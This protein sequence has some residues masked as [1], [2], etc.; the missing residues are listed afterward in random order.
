MIIGTA[1]FV[2]PQLMESVRLFANSF[3]GYYENFMRHMEKLETRDTLMKYIGAAV[4]ELIRSAENSIPVI[5]EKAYSITSSLIAGITGVLISAV[6]SVYLLTDKEK[7][8]LM[9]GKLMSAFMP[10]EKMYRYIRFTGLITG[11]FSRFICGQITEAAVLGVL[12]FIGMVIFGFNYPLLISAI[13][14]ITALV[15]VVGALVG[16]VPCAL[17]LFMIKPSQAVWFIVFIIILQQAENSVIYPKVVGKS[18]GL[19]P[20]IILIAIIIGAG[21][22]GAAGIMAGVPI[23]SAIYIILREKVGENLSA[24]NAE[25]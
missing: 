15:P 8:I 12:C 14:G 20:L 7:F 11:C 25:I 19:P 24:A 2:I 18:V 1:A 5:A 22:G 16:T 4:D 13:I 23:A 3:D 21:L 17:M 6:V 10:E 9:A